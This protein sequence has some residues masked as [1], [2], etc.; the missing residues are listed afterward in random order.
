M[1]FESPLFILAKLVAQMCEYRFLF[2]RIHFLKFLQPYSGRHLTFFYFQDCEFCDLFSG[3]F[4]N[5]SLITS[6]SRNRGL[7]D[8]RFTIRKNIIPISAHGRSDYF[9]SELCRFYLARRVLC[10]ERKYSQKYRQKI[11]DQH[12]GR[13]RG[14]HIAGVITSKVNKIQQLG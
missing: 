5:E 11:K 9:I 6:H 13:F 2:S 14:Y 8:H 7:V 12:A 4:F 1:I 10:A 3:F